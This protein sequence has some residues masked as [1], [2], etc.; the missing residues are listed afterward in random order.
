MHRKMDIRGKQRTRKIACSTTEWTTCTSSE[1]RWGRR[2]SDEHR[3]E[4]YAT[5]DVEEDLAGG[6]RHMVAEAAAC[7]SVPGDTTTKPAAVLRSCTFR[8]NRP[9]RTLGVTTLTRTG[10]RPVNTSSSSPPPPP[11]PGTA[12]RM[13]AATTRSASGLEVD[14]PVNETARDIIGKL[15]SPS[16]RWFVLLDII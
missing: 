10:T 7:I 14:V 11:P 12:R 3:E 5:P 16:I 8:A 6:R 4:E 2:E 9:H 15:T 13:K 1:V